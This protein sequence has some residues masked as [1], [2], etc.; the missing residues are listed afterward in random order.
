M[1]AILE[2]TEIWLLVTG[3]HKAEI[4]RQALEGPVE[5]AV[6]ASYLQRHSAVTVFAD[7]PAAALLRS[8]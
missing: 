3:A 2:S 5:P 7:V 8:A 1:R 6:P 4:L